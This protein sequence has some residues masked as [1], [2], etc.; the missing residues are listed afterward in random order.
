MTITEIVDTTYK[1]WQEGISELIDENNCSMEEK[2]VISKFPY[3]RLY[4]MGLPGGSYD[5]EGNEGAVTPTVQIDIYTNGQNAL[6]KAYQID[7]KSHEA[8]L[9]MGYRRT[10]GPE[11]TQNVDPTVKRLLSRYSRKIGY[12]DLL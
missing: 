6:L 1:N 8:M 9:G 10:Y 11:L 3:A 12:G 7:E 5:L 2:D 4:F